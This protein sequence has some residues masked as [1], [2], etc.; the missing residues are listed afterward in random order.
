M[1]LAHLARLELPLLDKC[2]YLRMLLHA[3]FWELVKKAARKSRWHNRKNARTAGDWGYKC[4]YGIV[5]IQI[6]RLS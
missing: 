6:V 5:V 4:Q 2:Y 1:Y 3:R